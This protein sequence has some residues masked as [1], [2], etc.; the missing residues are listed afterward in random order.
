MGCA[1]TYPMMS[2]GAD[3]SLY[4]SN[5]SMSPDH[6]VVLTPRQQGRCAQRM[7]FAPQ[8]WH[9]IE[10]GTVEGRED[11]ADRVEYT[12]ALGVRH[13][14]IQQLIGDEGRIRHHRTNPRL[15]ALARR[16]L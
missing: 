8:R 11:L 2:S 13:A 10:L 15:H 16:F 1:A 14:L 7:Y 6:A 12:G 4:S 3:I 5:T 9:A